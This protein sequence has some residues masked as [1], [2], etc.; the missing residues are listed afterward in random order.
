L[1]ESDFDH[2]YVWKKSE[3]LNDSMQASALQEARITCDGGESI[4]IGKIWVRTTRLSA[5]YLY[6]RP[7]QPLPY[8]PPPPCAPPKQPVNHSG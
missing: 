8:V 1:S 4:D 7:S 3:E 6:A 2:V 5:L